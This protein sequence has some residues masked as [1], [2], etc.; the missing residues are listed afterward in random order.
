VFQT[1]TF[2]LDKDKKE[3]DMEESMEVDEE[4]KEKEDWKVVG[5]KSK[6]S[7]SKKSKPS[8]LSLKNNVRSQDLDLKILDTKQQK[9]ANFKK[10]YRNFP[11]GCYS[12]NEDFVNK[13]VLKLSL[14]MCISHFKHSG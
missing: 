8:K 2:V 12:D 3:E 10:E 7:R 6:S 5:G 11:Y 13:L 9:N 4:P 14:V 1:L